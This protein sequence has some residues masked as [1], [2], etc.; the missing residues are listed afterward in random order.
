MLSLMY[1]CS[2]LVTPF[3]FDFAEPFKVEPQDGTLQPYSTLKLKASFQPK[4]NLSISQWK[5][6]NKVGEVAGESV[7]FIDVNSY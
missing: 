1:S 6:T 5:Q 7:A 2:Q 4:V 3:Q